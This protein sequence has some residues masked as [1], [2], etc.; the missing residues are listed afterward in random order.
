MYYAEHRIVDETN[1]PTDNIRGACAM[2]HAL[3]R[4]LSWRRSQDDWKLLAN[5]HIALYP[6]ADGHSV[7]G[8]APE[9][10]M[11]SAITAIPTRL[12]RW[13]KRSHSWARPLR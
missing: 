5:L 11:K 9:A 10:S 4:P 6:Q 1:I 8:L 2:C 7:L 3:A 12:C 13:T